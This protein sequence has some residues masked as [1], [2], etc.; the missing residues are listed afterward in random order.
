MVLKFTMDGKFLMRVG[1]KYPAADSNA[2][3]RF[4][5]VAKLAE[6]PKTNEMYHRG[7]LRQ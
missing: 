2:T 5:K 6:D 7:R 1:A 4:W 3:D